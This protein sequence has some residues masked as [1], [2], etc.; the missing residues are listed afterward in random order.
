MGEYQ[1]SVAR[2]ERCM[3][4]T[5]SGGRFGPIGPI[6]MAVAEETE[7]DEPVP[8]ASSLVALM[9]QLA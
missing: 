6:S 3:R 8:S 2:N 4:V 5:Q 1:R 9:A 7:E